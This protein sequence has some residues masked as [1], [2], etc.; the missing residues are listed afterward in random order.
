MLS[1]SLIR[2]MLTIALGALS[3]LCVV[4]QTPGPGVRTGRSASAASTIK[5]RVVNENGQPLSNAVVSVRP[6]NNSNNGTAVATDTDGSFQFN[7][8]D[9]DLTY[10]VVASMPAYTLPPPKEGAQAPT[11]RVGDSVNLTLVKGGVITGTVTNAIGEPIVGI[12]IR[13]EMVRRDRNGRR[14]AGVDVVGEKQTDDRGVYRI[15]GLPAG[16]YVVL[17]GGS[18]QHYSSSMVDPYETDAPTY[19]NSS[20]RDTASEITLRSGEEVSGV[21]IRYRAEQGRTVNGVVTGASRG[22][23]VTLTSAGDVQVPWN[24]TSY[25]QMDDNSFLFSGVAEGDYTLYAYSYG[26]K[27]D[28]GVSEIKRLQLRGADATGIELVTQPMATVAGRVVLDETK[29]P[30]CTGKAPD[31]GEMTVGAW[32]NDTEEAK[33]TPQQIWSL[34]TPVKPD[35]QGKFLLRNLATGEYYFAVRNV[36]KNWYVRSLQFTGTETAKKPVDVTRVFTNVKAGDQLSGLSITLAPGGASISGQ[37][38][39]GEG[40]KVPPRTFVYLAPV[41]RERSNNPLNYFGTPVSTEAKM[42]MNNIA[43]GRYWIFATTISED[44][45]VPFS[46]VRLPHETEIRA[47]I[48]RAA[49]AAKTEIE[50]KPCQEVVDFKVSLPG[51][52]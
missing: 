47:Q 17:A 2:I 29:L 32:H 51:N 45:L 39:L 8:L 26:D 23:N 25:R 34:G 24:A 41:E 31:F 1:Q 11:Y 20:T 42:G 48:R 35:A 15:Y 43:P 5:G 13:V 33:E 50:L 37:L 44:A 19:A 27:G 22:F 6:S 14:L 4:A 52:Q 9:Q 46:R 40:E 28:Y 10:Y 30:Q 36:G 3:S 21:D 18:S 7:E 12:R 16:T 49:E 38:A